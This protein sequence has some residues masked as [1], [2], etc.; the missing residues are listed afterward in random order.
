M[1]SALVL[2]GIKFQKASLLFPTY[3]ESD[4]KQNVSH[5]TIDR[6]QSIFNHGLSQSTRRSYTTPVSGYEMFCRHNNKCPYPLN[7][8]TMF[9]WM[10]ELSLKPSLAT[11]RVVTHRTIE[12]YC[13]IVGSHVERHGGVNIT[14]SLAFATFFR[15]LKRI[16]PHSVRRVK[17]GV[18]HQMITDIGV[19]ID[20]G[21]Y[22]NNMLWTILLIGYYGLLRKSELVSDRSDNTSGHAM[23]LKDLSFTGHNN[24]LELNIRLTTSKTDQFGERLDTVNISHSGCIQALREYLSLRPRSPSDKVFVHRDG[25]PVSY[26][27][28]HNTVTRWLVSIKALTPDRHIGWSVRKG[29]ATELASQ[30]IPMDQVAICGRWSSMRTPINHYIQY[31]TSMRISVMRSAQSNTPLET[32]SPNP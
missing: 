5:L 24:R 20:L 28:L 22:D 14:R 26:S 32:R 16:L 3:M 23:C 12:R 21:D 4:S 18:T 25:T 2:L 17:L 27:H 1:R 11:G 15:G 6:A 13:H 19:S 10:S 9:L 31:N 29:R 7:Q 30:G 8:E